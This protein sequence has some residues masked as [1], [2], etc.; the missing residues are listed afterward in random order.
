[1]ILGDRPSSQSNNRLGTSSVFSQR[2]G[3]HTSKNTKQ[4][5]VDLE[6]DDET[7][8]PLVLL[9][10][11][12]MLDDPKPNPKCNFKTYERDVKPHDKVKEMMRTYH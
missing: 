2:S 8:K 6:S 9:Q 10:R 3:L 11:S 1:M 5:T 12:R 7:I 4:L